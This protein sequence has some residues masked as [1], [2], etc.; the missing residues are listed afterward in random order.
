M[1]RWR[2]VPLALVVC[3]LASCAF[4]QKPTTLRTAV[5]VYAT[6]LTTLAEY[7]AAGLLS[8]SAVE[9]ISEA[10]PLVRSALDEWRT[11][12]EEDRSVSEAVA[13]YTVGM[14]VLERLSSDTR[15]VID[16]G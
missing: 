7:R 13:S 8:D 16:G 5:D 14:A 9:R 15:Y 2:I 6:T 11:A 12:L 4:M 1:R 10:A 3:V